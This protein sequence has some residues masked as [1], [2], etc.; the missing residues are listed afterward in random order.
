MRYSLVFGDE[1][2]P[3]E[4]GV[5]DLRIYRQF[6]EM[7]HHRRQVFGHK[8]FQNEDFKRRGIAFEPIP[9]AVGSYEVEAVSASKCN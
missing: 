8:A 5:A 2:Y 3:I 9:F 6:S 1:Q 7:V 4:S